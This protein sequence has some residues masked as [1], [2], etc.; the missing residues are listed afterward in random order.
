MASRDKR[1]VAAFVVLTLVGLGFAC[2]VI[3][4]LAM[5]ECLPRD[6]SAAMQACD[7]AKDREFWLYPL[8]V[9]LNFAT[10]VC[11]QV[12]GSSLGRIV[13]G[14][15]GITAVLVLSIIEML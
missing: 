2:V 11:L 5:G 8:L 1:D 14:S 7:T 10:S 15:S 13:A 9:L 4:W 3:L 6:G 12:R